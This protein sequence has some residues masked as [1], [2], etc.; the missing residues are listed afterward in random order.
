MNPN[1]ELFGWAILV[2]T[3]LGPIAAVLVTRYNDA[4]RAKHERQM[5]VFRTLMATRATDLNSERVAALNLIQIE[6]ANHPD[7]LQAW[8]GLLQ[9]FGGPDA[10]NEEEAKRFARERTRL[11][12]VL[13][14]KM[15]RRLGMRVEQLDILEG[16]YHPRGFWQ[17][18]Q[19]QQA[20]R[21]LLLEI[22][23]GQRAITV[24]LAPPATD[25]RQLAA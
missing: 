19:E 3:C 10:T 14:D 16:V 7:V 17:I 13:L 24:V 1:S 25:A 15:A 9:H 8:S 22:A 2:A 12:T 21:R 6:F 20:L 5:S 11:T 18:E 23:A 4:R